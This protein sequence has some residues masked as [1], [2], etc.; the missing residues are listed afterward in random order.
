MDIRRINEHYAEI[1]KELIE[2]EPAL[3]DIR[4]SEATICYLSSEHEKVADGKAVLG[5]CEKIQE[6]YKWAIPCDFTI[7]LFEPNIEGLSEEQIRIVILHELLHVGIKPN[8]NTG[9]E[10]YYV[11]PH[12][13]LPTFRIIYRQGVETED[14][15]IERLTSK[16]GLGISRIGTKGL[17]ELEKFVGFKIST[18]KVVASEHNINSI[19]KFGLILKKIE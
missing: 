2:S 10:D 1:G 6:K 9:G 5:Q 19:Y 3:E 16:N 17:E 4:F 8:F 11:K 14:E 12:E 18:K 7:T 13:S 15:L